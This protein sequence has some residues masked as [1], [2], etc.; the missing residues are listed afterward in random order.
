MT[1]QT[2]GVFKYP[3]MTIRFQAAIIGELPIRHAISLRLRPIIEMRDLPPCG[4]RHQGNETD[5]DPTRFHLRQRDRTLSATL[6]RRGD[7]R[8]PDR[9]S[10]FQQIAIPLQGIDR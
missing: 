1:P 2:E 5:R 7:L 9:I 3:H 10:R 8:R 4:A 6:A